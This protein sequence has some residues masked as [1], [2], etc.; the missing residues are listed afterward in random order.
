[1]DVRDGGVIPL[2]A[3]HRSEPSEQTQATEEAM[4]EVRLDD[5]VESQAFLDIMVGNLVKYLGTKEKVENDYFEHVSRTAGR[6]SM[7]HYI[8]LPCK[9]RKSFRN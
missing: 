2:A 1:M 8:S 7:R 4:I 3:K 5:P 9:P 6:T